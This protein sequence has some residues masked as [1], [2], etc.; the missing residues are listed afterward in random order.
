[1]HAATCYSTTELL[2]GGTMSLT[3]LLAVLAIIA[4]TFVL[5]G[6]DFFAPAL[7][8]YL[9]AIALNTLEVD[10]HLGRKS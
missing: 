3:A 4:G 2:R 7:L 10:V 5:F 8:W 6:A 1:M 9:L